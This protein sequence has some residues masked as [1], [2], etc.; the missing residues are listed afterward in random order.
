[1]VSLLFFL[2]DS[3]HGASMLQVSDL[4]ATLDAN[5]PKEP[6]GKVQS[7]V[8]ELLV[9]QGEEDSK[10]WAGTDG[11]AQQ[12]QP[13]FFWKSKQPMRSTECK[14]G[15][16]WLKVL[17]EEPHEQEIGSSLAAQPQEFF[18]FMWVHGCFL[19]SRSLVGSV[20]FRM[21]PYGSVSKKKP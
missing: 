19:K 7:I 20:W 11:R 17:K 14:H 3:S 2:K 9:I 8:Q 13:V 15:W 4:P 16:F 10:D 18:W 1:M 6:V 21:V 12:F 5:A